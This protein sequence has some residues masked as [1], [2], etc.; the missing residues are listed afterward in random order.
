[1]A[2]SLL[3]AS[4]FS[5]VW[6]P[7]DVL[8]HFTVHLT[9]LII[10]FV[11]GFFMPWER[12]LTVILLALMGFVGMSAYA[13]YSG[14]R[15]R[16]LASLSPNEKQLRLMTFNTSTINSNTAA[17]SAEVR[18]LHPDIAVLIEFGEGKR[19]VLDQLRVLYPYG[20]GCVPGRHCH[21][22]VLS[23]VPIIASEVREGWKGPLMV[24][25]TLGGEFSGLNIVGIHAA[26]MPHLDAQHLQMSILAEY[27]DSLGGMVVVMGDFNATPFSRLLSD[28]S[29]RTELHRLTAIPSWPAYLEL[30]QFAIDHVFVSRQLRPIEGVL[31]GRRS[32]SDHYP[33]TAMVKMPRD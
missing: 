15:E 1:M 16:T 30:P 21:F 8:S 9:I 6:L 4:K 10:A 18:R 5:S 17:L 33:V 3:G 26:R 19:A 14:E 2:S 24:R 27:L 22:A 31:I 11:L 13:H 25:A 23:K 29:D 20:A 28:F 12:M 32:G 7:L